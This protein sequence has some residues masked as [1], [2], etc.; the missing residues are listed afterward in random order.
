MTK[1]TAVWYVELRIQ[2]VVS[3]LSSSIWYG[4]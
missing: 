4:P 3:F 2:T 1:M